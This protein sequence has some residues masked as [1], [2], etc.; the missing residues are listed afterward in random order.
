MSLRTLLSLPRAAIPVLALLA[1]APAAA[2]TSITLNISG[3]SAVT[4][5]KDD[6]AANLTVNWT[7]ATGGAAGCS[8]LVAWVTKTATCGTAPTTEDLTLGSVA[9]TTWPV[10]GTGSFPLAVSDLPVF[11]GTT[12]PV[13]NVEE[14]MRV[15]AYATYASFSGCSQTL[16]AKPGSPPTITYDAK[17]PAAPSITRVVPQDGALQIFFTAPSDAATVIVLYT[18]DPSGAYDYGPEVATSNESVRV[19]GLT[20]GTTYAVAL[21]AEDAAGNRSTASEAASGTPVP[22]YGFF[23]TYRNMGGTEQGCAAAPAGACPLLALGW[24]ARRRR[25]RIGRGMAAVSA[26]LLASLAAPAMAQGSIGVTERPP[27]EIGSERTTEVEVKLG[28][29]KPM[30]DREFSTDGSTGPY[31]KVFGESWMLLIEVAGERQLFQAFGSAGV[32]FSAGYAEKFA[33]ALL[34]NDELASE[35]TGLRVFPFKLFGVYRFDYAAHTWGVPLVP[36]VKAGL[37]CTV[38]SS[39]KGATLEALGTRWGWGVTGGL[40][41]LLDVFEPRLARDFD[42][43]VGVNHSYLFAEFNYAQVNNFSSTGGIN[44][45]GQYAMFGIA[46]EI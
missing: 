36:F 19:E 8:N 14:T 23:T 29:F 34:E 1:S 20:N 22:S 3:E 5:N 24:L 10:Q 2:Q 17:P 32:G 38:W 31:S 13:L 43:D 27:G 40:A 21:L 6:C 9:S 12:C 45:S 46:F 11:N 33:P 39:T 4:V 44:L 16:E 30:I 15:C 26:A 18:S 37:H 28:G 35:S 25:R 42:T 41:L 7:V